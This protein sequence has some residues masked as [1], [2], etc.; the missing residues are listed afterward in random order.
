MPILL[1]SDPVLVKIQK[2][3][4]GFGLK[5]LLN[6]KLDFETDYRDTH[7]LENKNGV[8][9]VSSIKLE[10]SSIDYVNLINKQEYTNYD[11]NGIR[12]TM[13]EYI[14]LLISRIFNQPIYDI[15]I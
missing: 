12:W 8:G 9:N 13:S 6:Y 3:L 2:D 4:E 7:L 5:S 14:L 1:V 15:V 11:L 10:N